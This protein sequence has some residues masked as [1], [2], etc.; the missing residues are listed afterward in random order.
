MPVQAGGAKPLSELKSPWHIHVHHW[1]AANPGVPYKVALQRAKETYTSP[2]KARKA[3]AKAAPTAGPQKQYSPWV[4]HVKA[5]QASHPGMSYK[6]A[7][8]AARASYV[9]GKRPA[10]AAPVHVAPAPVPEA[11]IDQEGDEIEAEPEPEPVEVKAAEGLAMAVAEDTRD[12]QL[13][14]HDAKLKGKQAE[15]ASVL[16]DN[17]AVL[18]KVLAGLDQ[19]EE[20]KGRGDALRVIF[21]V[22]YDYIG[23]YTGADYELWKDIFYVTGPE[24]LEHR[25]KVNETYHKLKY[26]V[27]KLIR[28]VQAGEIDRVVD[29]IRDIWEEGGHKVLKIGY[30]ALTDDEVAAAMKAIN[31][32]W[33]PQIEEYKAKGWPTGQ[34]EIEKGQD[35]MM[36]RMS[37]RGMHPK[38]VKEVSQESPYGK[39]MNALLLAHLEQGRPGGHS[40]YMKKLEAVQKKYKSLNEYEPVKVLKEPKDW[41]PKVVRDYA[42][43]HLGSGRQMGG[44]RT[45]PRCG[46][47]RAV[48]RCATAACKGCPQC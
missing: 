37:A 29:W 34:L 3:P 22:I 24:A 31:D 43:G 32:K 10:P 6:D 36:V 5:Y 1:R 26:H 14:E 27:E 47:G 25:A 48:C 46:C 28:W 2:S 12:K 7:M 20:A 16:R 39:E 33:D 44:G 42:R 45:R 40:G 19:E 18:R 13:E 4:A 21:E 8:S 15:N 23:K 17:E 35:R 11:E 38:S 30:R 41:D 9:K